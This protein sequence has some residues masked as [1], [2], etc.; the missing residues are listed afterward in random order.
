MKAHGLGEQRCSYPIDGDLSLRTPAGHGDFGT[1]L[2]APNESEGATF[3]AVE[4]RPSSAGM[5]AKLG[6]NPIHEPAARPAQLPDNTEERMIGSERVAADPY[7]VISRLD[8]LLAHV[9]E[10][11]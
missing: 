9:I 2:A 7:R 8:D 11:R 3:V 4:L 5:G 1:V 6:R 10:E